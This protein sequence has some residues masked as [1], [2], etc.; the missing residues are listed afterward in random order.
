MKQKIVYEYIEKNK[1]YLFPNNVYTEIQVE[2]VLINAPEQTE[3]L[4]GEI[5]F[6]NPSTLQIIAV[7]PGMLGVD[8]FYM[9]EILLGFFK[10]IT[11]GGCGIWWILDIMNAKS[12][13]REWNCKKLI[14]TIYGSEKL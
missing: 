3:N 12:R 7:F 14:Q 8:R 11:L 10:Y 5:S 9:G 4:L 2:N 1:E 6:R 13:C